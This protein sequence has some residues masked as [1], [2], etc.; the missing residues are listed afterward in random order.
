MPAFSPMIN[1]F[2]RIS[3]LQAKKFTRWSGK[4]PVPITTKKLSLPK[5]QI[6][7]I[8]LEGQKPVLPKLLPSSSALWRRE[9]SG[10]I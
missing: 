7:T 8:V 6:S 4:C 1:P 5:A 2:I 3:E 10:F 9:P